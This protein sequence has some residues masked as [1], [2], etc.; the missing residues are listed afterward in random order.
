MADMPLPWQLRPMQEADL[1]AVAALEA[2]CQFTPWSEQ[3][4]RDCLGE[5]YLCQVVTDAAGELVAFAVIY[6]VLDEAHLLNIAVAPAWQRQ[7]VAAALLRALMD[8]L[9]PE[10]LNLFLEV[11]QSNQPART[12][13]QRLGFVSTGLRKNYYR[14]PQGSEHAVLMRCD[15]GMR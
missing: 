7:G 8:T 1:A 2:Q 3:V 9:R 14:A 6:R 4:F 13:Y 10:T 12:L 11:R 15:L 5:Q